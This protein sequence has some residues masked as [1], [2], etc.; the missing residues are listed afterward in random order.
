MILLI[1][2]GGDL[3]IL[4]NSS[5][6]PLAFGS[7]KLLNLLNLGNGVATYEKKGYRLLPA[8]VD[9]NKLLVGSHY[10]DKNNEFIP[11]KY[12]ALGKATHHV[13]DNQ[14]QINSFLPINER[15]SMK[16]KSNMLL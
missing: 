11:F 8:E 10:D 3:N 9:N 13:L 14:K 2:K 5:Q 1:S 12:K 7:Q 4:N 6:T 15:S 16:K